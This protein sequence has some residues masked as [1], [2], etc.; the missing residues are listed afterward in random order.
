MV[1]NKKLNRVIKCN[2]LFLIVA[3]MVSFKKNKENDTGINGPAMDGTASSIYPMAAKEN[4]A[5]RNTQCTNNKTVSYG[6]IIRGDSTI[7]NI[8]LVFT[9]DEFA[10]GGD[11]IDSVLQSKN[12]NGSFFL[13]GNFY[14][15][16]QFKNLIIRLKGHGNYLGPHS[17]KHL[18]YCDWI[19]RDSLLI[20]KEAFKNDLQAAYK[21]LRQFSIGKNDAHYF[22]PPYEWHNDSI[23]SWTKEMGLQLINFTPGTR[24]NADYTYPEQE[25]RYVS[26]DSVFNSI[27]NY[28]QK[29]SGGLNGFILLTHIGTDPRRT[30][31]FYYKLP[32]LIDTL[33]SRKYRFVT[34]DKLLQ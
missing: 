28:E 1:L 27:L 33:K 3:C 14:S 26:S 25:S 4:E 17:D 12:M 11:F 13:T 19:K 18:L 10:D 16:Q 29:S 6:A 7:K 30:D 34:I 21:K 15:N 22:L 32:A 20:T 8:A 2:V 31:K 24:S 9:G 5:R 23:A